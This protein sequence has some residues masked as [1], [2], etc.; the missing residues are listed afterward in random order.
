[1]K[2]R[3][4]AKIFGTCQYIILR[5]RITPFYLKFDFNEGGRKFVFNLW[6]NYGSY[7]LFIYMAIDR[8]GFWRRRTKKI[9][10]IKEVTNEN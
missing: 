10:K 8:K 9:L 5:I 6:I 1:M 3:L 2:I 4:P 7:R